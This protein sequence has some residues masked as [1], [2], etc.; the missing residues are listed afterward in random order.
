MATGTS[1]VR[2]KR[3]RGGDDRPTEVKRARA[4]LDQ[5]ECKPTVPEA[6]GYVS[7][8]RLKNVPLPDEISALPHVLNHLDTLLMTPGEALK[9]AIEM[10]DLKWVQEL[11]D[12]YICD[13]SDAMAEAAGLN[14]RDVVNLLIKDIFT[15]SGESSQAID[16]FD[17]RLDNEFMLVIMEK[18][19]LSAARNGHVTIVE[20][21]LPMVIDQARN[22]TDYL[23][24]WF[25]HVQEI[26]NE[27]AVNG[28]LEVVKFMVEHAADDHYGDRY[29]RWTKDDTLTKAI[30][31]GHIDVAEFL[32]NQSI[33]SLNLKNAFIVAVDKGQESLAERIR[34]LYPQRLHGA[35][36]FIDLISSG[37]LNAV[38]YLY[39]NGCNDSDLVGEAFVLAASGAQNAVVE[40]LAG[41]GCVSSEA[42]EE[43]FKRACSG[44]SSVF[45]DTVTFL[46]KLNTVSP[47]CIE[48]GFGLANSF[49]VVKFLYENEKIS[50]KAIIAAFENAVRLCHTE[51]SDIIFFL[52]KHQCIPSKLIGKAFL[53]AVKSLHAG[54]LGDETNLM[55]TH[56]VF[57][58]RGDERV[59]PKA[60]GEALVNA[61]KNGKKEIMLFLYHEQRTPPEFLVKAFVEAMHRKNTGVVKEILKLLSV[62][63][64]VP[65]RFMHETFVA[66]T[67][68]GQMPI[69]ELVYGNLPTD[70]PLE[71][72]KNA[73]DVAGGNHKIESFIRKIA[74]DQ[75][76]KEMQ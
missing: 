13:Y 32:V 52:Y 22:S 12:R 43:A 7:Y 30:V 41:T 40:A 68:H 70:L 17:M 8:Q 66:A 25:D 76:F 57:S 69:L 58:L 34:E 73:L 29:L 49:G 74:C 3:D 44:D 62:E 23:L 53:H 61:A 15:G 47:Q 16:G 54:H 71:V 36:L 18:G 55:K 67:R 51:H 33:I 4:S 28:Q 10:N 45:L 1:N 37:D 38:E 63:E 35:D 5:V 46:Y 9:A 59:S 42:F 65:R 39:K 64:H 21:L 27:G 60:M 48:H 24:Y 72:L 19:A 14:R 56:V 26:M 11:L 31:A 2:A 20:R 6:V 50:D 75:I